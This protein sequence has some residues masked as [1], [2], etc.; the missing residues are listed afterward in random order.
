M[1][2]V[3]QAFDRGI[4]LPFLPFCKNS[5]KEGEEKRRKRDFKKIF[6][7]LDYAV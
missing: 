6:E 7:I 2:L 4:F 3:E 1:S 5:E